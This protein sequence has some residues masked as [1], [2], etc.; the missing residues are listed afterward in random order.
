MISGPIVE[1][2][3]QRSE[4]ASG[5][6]IAVSKDLVGFFEESHRGFK[7]HCEELE[8]SL[9]KLTQHTDEEL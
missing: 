2:Q 8:V 3:R 4:T 7:I 9:V 6:P 5:F 1:D